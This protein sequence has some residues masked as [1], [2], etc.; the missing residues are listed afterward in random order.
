[1]LHL[2]PGPFSVIIVVLASKVYCNSDNALAGLI[3]EITKGFLYVPG[4]QLRELEEFVY[5]AST[6]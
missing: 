5:I 6:F 3:R 4:F 2:F 1:M